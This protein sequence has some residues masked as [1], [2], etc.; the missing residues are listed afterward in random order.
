MYHGWPP[1]THQFTL[2]PTQHF[3]APHPQPPPPPPAPVLREQAQRTLI[4][5]TQFPS[6]DHPT[7]GAGTKPTKR[8]YRTKNNPE[9]INPSNLNTNSTNSVLDTDPLKSIILPTSYPSFTPDEAK[10]LLTKPRKRTNLNEHPLPAP[11]A[12]MK[13]AVTCW[14]AKFQDPKTGLGFADMHQYK[15]IQRVVA[16]GCAWS[17]ML[18]AWVG[19]RMGAMGRPAR[20][21]PE[22]FAGENVVGGTYSTVKAEN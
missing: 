21:V 17:G 7:E 12:R 11:P 5:L 10:Y 15:A 18:G 14:K 6:L 19:P 22:G 13:C 9:G 3:V 20:G 4:I 2:K 8:T 1:G 16:G